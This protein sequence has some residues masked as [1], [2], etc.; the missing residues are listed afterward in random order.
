VDAARKHGKAVAMVT[1]SAEGV[2][3]MVALGATIINYSSDAAVLRAGYAGAL[4][5]MR[6]P[7]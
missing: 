3:Q 4:D 7:S 2:R 5:A 1:D 6:K